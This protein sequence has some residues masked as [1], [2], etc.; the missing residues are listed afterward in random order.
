ML[1]KAINR[2]QIFRRLSKLQTIKTN[3]W[4]NKHIKELET[5][6]KDITHAMLSSEKK[7]MPAHVAPWSP[8][9]KEQYNEI[10]WGKKQLRSQMKKIPQNITKINSL[11]EEITQNIKIL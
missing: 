11:K 7:C 5:L 3:A 1:L 8:K 10:K 4:K 2:K 6:D 9:I